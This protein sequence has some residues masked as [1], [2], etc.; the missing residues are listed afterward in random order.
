MIKKTKVKK[1]ILVAPSM[2]PAIDSVHIIQPKRFDNRTVTI[3]LLSICLGLIAS[4]VAYSLTGL[5]GFFTNL[6]YY[7]RFSLTFV[8]PSE[9]PHWGLWVIILPVI[10]GL[11]VGL[12]ARFGS[13]A[14]RGH[15]IPEAMEQILQNKSRIPW[16]MV[17][18][19]PISAA[20][21]IG[22]GGPFG[23]EGPIIATGG[24]LGSWL[25]QVVHISATERKT[26]LAAG[27]A[28]GMAATFGSP[29]S[30]VLLAVELL[31]FEFR[32]RSLVPV[33]LASASAS[34]VRLELIGNQ[35]VFIMP[36]L[37]PVSG[38]EIIFYV[39]MGIFMGMGALVVTR[40][41]YFIEDCF[42]KLPIHWMWW[43]A[44]GGIAVGGIGFYF[45][46]TLGVGYENIDAILSGQLA[47]HIVIV[48]CLMK[49]LSWVISLGSGTSG[50][51][52][53][54]LFM[55]GGGLG[56]LVGTF[57]QN[58]IPWLHID[59]KVTALVGM[60]SLFAGASGALLTSVIFAFETTGQQ[61]SLLPLLVGCCVSYLVSNY[62][63]KNTIM[64]EKIARRGVKVPNEYT[65]NFLESIPASKLCH[66]HLVTISVDETIEDISEKITNDTNYSHQG[67]PVVDKMGELIGVVTQR[68]IMNNK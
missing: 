31:L 26:L 54:P 50:G 51:T 20:I 11:I 10:G 36:A 2:R 40:S 13:S 60:A 4:Y 55:I 66:R 17:F 22:S 52:L 63:M 56:T 27:A 5:I 30:A 19:K 24:A 1:G 18:L 8:Q 47:P 33:A 57:S 3:C 35:P 41:V 38:Y 48:F 68:E 28:A 62:F 32:P 64:T 6:F 29:I 49:F 59:L 43:P 37:S 12:M 53:A 58:M 65:P 34:S 44:I 46:K 67:Y 7:Q 25:G 61:L 21:S 39:L 9:A 15:G 16:R 42:E 45:P 23:A 14:I